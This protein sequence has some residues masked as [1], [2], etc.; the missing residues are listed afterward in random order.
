MEV[1]RVFDPQ[2]AQLRYLLKDDGELYVSKAVQKAYIEVNEEGT[3]AGA[4]NVGK[5]LVVST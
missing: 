2:Q 3:E 5:F 1:K 4:E